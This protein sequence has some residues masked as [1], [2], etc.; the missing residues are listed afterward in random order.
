MSTF[1]TMFSKT[2]SYAS[3]CVYMWER[4]R[5]FVE[6]FLLLSLGFQNSTAS[7]APTCV[8]MRERVKMFL[9]TEAL[10]IYD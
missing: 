7:I 3:K 6:H 9:R 5:K 1:V 10:F 8:Y 4:V 2:A